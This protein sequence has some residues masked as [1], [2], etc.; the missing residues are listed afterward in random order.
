HCQSH[1]VKTN[2]WDYPAR[3]DKKNKR[4]I[5]GQELVKDSDLFESGRR[6]APAR[7]PGFPGNSMLLD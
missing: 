7:E 4:G 5:F 3:K 1:A 6:L 2:P